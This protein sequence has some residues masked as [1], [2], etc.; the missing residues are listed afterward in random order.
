[1]SWGVQARPSPD[2]TLPP[3]LLLRTPTIGESVS[4]DSPSLVAHSSSPS[5]SFCR[6]RRE[7]CGAPLCLHLQQ[8]AASA[9]PGLSGYTC[10]TD[11][12]PK[13]LC[14][15]WSEGGTF[16]GAEPLS[17]PRLLVSCGDLLSRFWCRSPKHTEAWRCKACSAGKRFSE[18]RGKGVQ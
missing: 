4:T 6:H 15:S 1:M 13:S 8:E 10:A 17:L 3:G 18:S 7:I 5:R 12:L 9:M 11:S 16:P 2:S 14:V